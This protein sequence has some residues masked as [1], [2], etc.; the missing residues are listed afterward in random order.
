M[1]AAASDTRI[2]HAYLYAGQLIAS[3]LR[4][5]LSTQAKAHINSTAKKSFFTATLPCPG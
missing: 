4:H 5:P 2:A 3:Q 1:N